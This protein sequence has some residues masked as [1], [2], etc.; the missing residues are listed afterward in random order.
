MVKLGRPKENPGRPEAN[1]G[2]GHF[3]LDVLELIVHTEA[4][5]VGIR[6]NAVN[7][8]CLCLQGILHLLAREGN[9][10]SLP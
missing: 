8:G 10:D 3:S 1:R 4:G 2:K 9:V 5:L 6:L 7:I